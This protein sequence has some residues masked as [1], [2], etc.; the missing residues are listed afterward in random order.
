MRKAGIGTIQGI[1]MGGRMINN[2]KY[3]DDTTLI[4]GNFND[5]KILINTVIE[6][7]KK[8]GLRLNI[9]KT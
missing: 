4:S 3:A 6:T 8:A 9:K 2:L 7:S 5:L 1:T